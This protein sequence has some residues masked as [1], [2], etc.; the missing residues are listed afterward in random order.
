LHKLELEG[1]VEIVP[2]KYCRVIGIRKESIHE[3]NLIR[4]RLEPIVCMDAVSNITEEKL[5]YMKKMLEQTEEYFAKND[6][7]KVIYSNDQFHNTLI[8]SSINYKRIIRLLENL[9][10]YV[11]AF[12]YSFMMRDDLVKRTI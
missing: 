12:R 8:N 11:V 10:D 7:E 6:I 5:S 4:S 9:H 2:R 3:I 1:L